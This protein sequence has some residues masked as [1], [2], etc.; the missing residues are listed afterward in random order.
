[1]DFE[2][3]CSIWKLDG[4]IGRWDFFKLNII[5]FVIA[6]IVGLA[7]HSPIGSMVSILILPLSLVAAY[8]MIV[9]TIKRFWDV[10]ADRTTAIVAFVIFV[11]I[12][13]FIPFAGLAGDIVLFLVPGQCTQGY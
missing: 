8:L 1:M 3:S 11:V 10:F 7:L 2:E 5:L 12:S 13:G 9:A 6:L 4:P